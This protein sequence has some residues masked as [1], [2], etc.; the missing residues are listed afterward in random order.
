MADK[1]VL[2]FETRCMTTR[3]YYKKCEPAVNNTPNPSCAFA[4]VKA[5]RMYDRSLLRIEGNR[6][7]L[8]KSREDAQRTSNESLS[9][10]FACNA[11]GNKAIEID[12][13]F[14]GLNAYK[15]KMNLMEGPSFGDTVE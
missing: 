10:E 5:D 8:A 2:E 12:I 9:W 6:P 13:P 14:P 1:N 11:T 3:L 4:C 15:K 7:V